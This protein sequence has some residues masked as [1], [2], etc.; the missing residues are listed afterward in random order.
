MGYRNHKMVCMVRADVTDMLA[1]ERRKKDEL[2]EALVL[3]E[4]ASREKANS[5]QP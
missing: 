2:R 4:E 3:A 5:F 1:E